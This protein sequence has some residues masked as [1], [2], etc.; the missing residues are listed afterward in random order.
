MR[1]KRFLSGALAGAFLAS[2]LAGG[3]AG[4]NPGIASV[5]PWIRRELAREFRFR[6][7]DLTLEQLIDRLNQ[8]LRDGISIDPIRRAVPEGSRKSDE[9]RFS[10]PAPG[11]GG[12]APTPRGATL[13]ALLDAAGQALDFL[14]TARR[15]VILVRRGADGGGP[16]ER[17]NGT[18][19]GTLRAGW[20]GFDEAARIDAVDALSE[21]TG[22]AC[23]DLLIAALKAEKGPTDLRRRLAAA[24]GRIGGAET[25]EPLRAILMAETHDDPVLCRYAAGALGRIGD[26]AATEA[27]LSVLASAKDAGARRC[28]AGA[29]RHVGGPA[30]IDALFACFLGD[31]DPMVWGAASGSLGRI[32]G[33]AVAKRLRGILETHAD[34]KR[35][36]AAATALERAGF[37]RESAGH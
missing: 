28:A 15:D 26:G 12:E 17:S 20:A 18:D 25:V 11:S 2:C 24:L 8:D 19:A 34:P 33:E 5:D 16:P 32:G 35:R 37:P 7:V 22:R 9:P 27:L 23:A 14:W 36:Q 10:W 1:G 21:E 4:G 31:P 6:C 29:L 13:G 30:A 3:I